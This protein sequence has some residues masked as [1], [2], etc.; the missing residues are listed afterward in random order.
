MPIRIEARG[1]VT[2]ALQIGY[3]ERLNVL[4]QSVDDMEASK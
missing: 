2:D 1:R 4:E 3:N